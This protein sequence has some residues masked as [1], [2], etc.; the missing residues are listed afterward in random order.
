MEQQVKHGDA[1][2]T[3]E[4]DGPPDAPALLLIN[5]IGSTREMWSRQ[6]PALTG[7][8]RV[9]RYDARGHGES[10]AP[11]GPYTLEQLGRD[12]L[13]ILDGA[14]ASAAHVCGISL[15]GM[16]AM[17]LGINAP[18]RVR[19]LVLANTAARIGTVDGWNDRIATVRQHGMSPAAEQAMPR[20]FSPAFH[21]RDPETVHVFRTMVQNCGVEG[22]LGCCA[23]LRDADV[24]DQ[25]SRIS[26]PT[27]AIASSQDPATPP[28][29]LAFI[30]DRIPGARMVTFDAGHLSNVECAE[31]F[32]A[33]VLDFLK[34]QGPGP[35]A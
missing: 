17:W 2:L 20:W 32:T 21:E 29:G 6:M 18:D 11:R 7:A 22:Y 27:L 24:R 35:K 33:A 14:G 3:Y 19:S 5:S 12:A 8:Y 4:V 16:T 10:S 25:L 30:R 1:V 31:E 28:E 9:I 15:G 13:A 26:V 23:A 34:A